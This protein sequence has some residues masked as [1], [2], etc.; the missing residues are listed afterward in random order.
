MY[1]QNLIVLDLRNTL[2]NLK[3]LILSLSFDPSHAWVLFSKF[4]SIRVLTRTSCPGCLYLQII[5]RQFLLHRIAP[6]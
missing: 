5:R 3:T 1:S 6:R 2:P 4:Q